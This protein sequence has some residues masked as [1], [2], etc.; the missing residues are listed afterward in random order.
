MSSIWSCCA[1][2]A[3]PANVY[4]KHQQINPL[5]F[6]IWEDTRQME[7]QDFRWQGGKPHWGGPWEAEPQREPPGALGN[8][9]N[10]LQSS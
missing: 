9:L 5:R 2:G 8:L 3:M 6:K 1:W 4:G 7:K 10:K